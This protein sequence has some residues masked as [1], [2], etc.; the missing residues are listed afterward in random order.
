MTILKDSSNNSVAQCDGCGRSDAGPGSNLPIKEYPVHDPNLGSV[1][2]H[3]YCHGCASKRN[4]DVQLLDFGWQAAPLPPSP[5]AEPE[6]DGEHPRA[7][8]AT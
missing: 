4:A 6:D 3:H 8:R 5:P 7:R 1:V 2:L